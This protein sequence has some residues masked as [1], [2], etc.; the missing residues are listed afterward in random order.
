M[1]AAQALQCLN[2]GKRVQV[3]T[4]LADSL[5][6]A[7]AVVAE[8]KKTGLVALVGHTRRSNPSH[9]FVRERILGPAALKA[10]VGGLP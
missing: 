5:K 9:Q 4:P 2:A 10:T 6:D 8:Q 3:E 7:N 1:R